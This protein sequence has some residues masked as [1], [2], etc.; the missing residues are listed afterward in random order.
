MATAT[1]QAPD[2]TRGGAY[3][4]LQHYVIHY[5][6]I[7]SETVTPGMDGIVHAAFQPDEISDVVVVTAA[8]ATTV[9]AIAV[10]GPHSGTLHVWARA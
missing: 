3:A 9:T 6:S 4:G 2:L 8:S 7:D 1:T 5:S 10:A